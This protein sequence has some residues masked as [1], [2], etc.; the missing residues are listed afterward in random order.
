MPTECAVADW[1]QT[2]LLAV[3]ALSLA[4]LAWQAWTQNTLLKAQL[5]RDRFEM[6]WKTYEPISD[7]LVSQVELYPQDYMDAKR[8]HAAYRG[9]RDAIRRYLYISMLYE[10]LAFTYALHQRLRIRDPLGKNWRERWTRELTTSQEFQ[11]VNKY[12]GDYYPDFKAEVD[13]L[14]N[15]GARPSR[16]K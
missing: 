16:A 4:V 2:G 6:Y 14:V 1:I 13:R 15:S 5:L 7:E 9:K 11:D 3:G 10:N 12:Y 8:Y